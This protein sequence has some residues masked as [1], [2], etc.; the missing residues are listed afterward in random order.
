MLLLN[1]G[2]ADDG[3]RE[4]RRYRGGR[5]LLEDEA[6]R[7]DEGP[8]VTEQSRRLKS[9]SL[10][11]FISSR[12]YVPMADIRR[13]FG[14]AT[15]T[16]T[17]L[18]DDEGSVHIGLPQ[19]AAEALLD[20]TRKQRV[21]LQYDLEHATRIVVGAYPI[22]IRLTPPAS[23]GRPY[24]QAPTSKPSAASSGAVD[25]EVAVEAP[26]QAAVPRTSR[27]LTSGQRRRRRR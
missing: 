19:Q 26:P 18:H 9:S 1:A 2:T 14:L 15:E 11:W 12:P 4:E 3:A 25:D 8:P 6:V 21:G 10:L 5:D 20:L 27:P 16:G 24:Q 22:R 17:V 23:N 7:V 13:R